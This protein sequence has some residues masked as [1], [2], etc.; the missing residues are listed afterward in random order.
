M[1]TVTNVRERT[2]VYRNGLGIAT[3][4]RLT[5]KSVETVVYIIE[6]NSVRVATVLKST[7]RS[8]AT[9]VQRIIGV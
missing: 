2:V 7:E 6:G 9:V 3:V 1:Q 4:L 8:A 5:L